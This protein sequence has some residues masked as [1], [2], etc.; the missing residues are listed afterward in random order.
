MNFD[1]P[2]CDRNKI[3]KTNN[4]LRGKRQ[5]RD[6]L[7]FVVAPTQ[8]YEYQIYKSCGFPISWKKICYSK[9]GVQIVPI[10]VDFRDH[11]DLGWLALL[12]DLDLTVDST[13]T[14]ILDLKI[15]QLMD[16]VFFGELTSTVTL[17]LV[18]TLF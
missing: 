3:A 11:L 5:Y 12:F 8:H 9:L 18:N 6:L 7:P 15:H 17:M 4:Q 13:K 1:E 16:I 10:R 2:I 14:A